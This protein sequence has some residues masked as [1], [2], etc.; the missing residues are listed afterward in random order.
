MGVFDNIEAYDPTADSW[1]EFPPMV[2][3]RHGYGAGQL[4]GRI[5]LMGGA[6]MQGGGMASDS[7]T[8]YYFEP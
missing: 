4:D 6:L 8:V 7:A 1:E 3:P 5:Y 2:L